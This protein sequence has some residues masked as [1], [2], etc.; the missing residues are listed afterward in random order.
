MGRSEGSEAR[1]PHSSPSHSSDTF[2]GC[3]N[4]SSLLLEAPNPH[5]TSLPTPW[6]RAWVLLEI[7]LRLG[8]PTTLSAPEAGLPLADLLLWGSYSLWPE[9]SLNLLSARGAEGESLH[10]PLGNSPFP[11]AFKAVSAAPG[12]S[13]AE[14]NPMRRGGIV[15]AVQ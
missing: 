8:A 4:L 3:F 7:P 9:K 1:R 12:L 13:H 14:G 15:C 10:T 6:H 2:R 5:P 11:Q